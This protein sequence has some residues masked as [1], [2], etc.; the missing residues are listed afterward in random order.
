VALARQIRRTGIRRV[1][2]SVVGDESFFDPQRT[3]PGWKPSF[4]INE[5]PP[6][7]ALVVDRGI[8]RGRVARKP[9][10]AAAALFRA[11]LEE[12]GVQVDRPSKSVR[13][14]GVPLAS[15]ES[16]PLGDLVRTMDTDSDNFFAE[17]LLKELGAVVAHTG[18]SHAGAAVAI[19]VLKEAEIPLAGVR[20]VDG[21][22]LSYRDRLTTSALVA[23]LEHAWGDLAL[24][25]AF[26]GSLAVA[27]RSGTLEH[28][29]LERPAY[30]AVRAKTGTTDVAS[31]LSGFVKRRYAFSILQNGRPIAFWSARTAQDRFAEVLAA[32]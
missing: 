12:N 15:V 17:M 2:G 20:I 29:M 24:R 30:G 28:R 9:A 5:C 6:L 7:S 22:G 1:A 10:L 18:T 21:S 23:I 25:P 26:L 4:Y 31:A 3:G 16:E 27:G 32:Q 8:Y 14:S 19:H 11:A 13:A